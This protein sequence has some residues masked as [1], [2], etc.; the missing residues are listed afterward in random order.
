ML[1][2]RHMTIITGHPGEGETTMA[3]YLALKRSKPENCL[4]LANANDWR[5]V[6]WSLK[7]FNTVI[8]D[9]IFGAGAL[10]NNY[11]SD[12]KVYL[13]EI[14]RAAKHKRLNVIITY[15]HYIKEEAL[16]YINNSSMFRTQEGNIVHLSSDDLS[17]EE[18]RGILKMLELRVKQTSTENVKLFNEIDYYEC[19]L[20]SKGTINYDSNTPENVVCG[21]HQCA[22]LFVHDENLMKL[23]ASFFENPDAHFKSY[24]EQLY[25]VNDGDIFQRFVALVIVWADHNGRIKK[26]DVRNPASATGH[27][28]H[29]ADIFGIDVKR[30]FMEN[31]RSS[32]KS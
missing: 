3:A 23:G 24:I 18:K 27:I 10:N 13:P 26:Y 15:R 25:N 1:N 22:T 16:D 7:L 14:E 17:H 4:K 29:V 9:D 5:K 19:V 21:F 6:D 20:K 31:I 30:K 28:R 32:L 8:I 2:D 11:V 12:W